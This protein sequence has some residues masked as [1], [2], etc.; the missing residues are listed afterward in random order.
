MSKGAHCWVRINIFLLLWS[1]TA[2]G[3]PSDPGGGGKRTVFQS[4][5]DLGDDF[6][7]DDEAGGAIVGALSYGS[8]DEPPENGLETTGSM[9]S[10]KT[11]NPKSK[12]LGQ[13]SPT[14]TTKSPGSAK[15]HH[16][17]KV[18]KFQRPK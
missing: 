12:K 18:I 8:D 11:P 6:V 1:A 14:V 17:P 5:D 7:S 2:V 3:E 13:D 9:K 15:M 4:G 16:T 10:T